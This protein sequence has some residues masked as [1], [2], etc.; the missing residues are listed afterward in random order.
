MRRTLARA[1]GVFVT[2]ALAALP[3]AATILIFAW[4]GGLLLRWLGPDSLIGGLLVAIGLG[5][6]GS[7]WLAYLIGVLAVSLGLFGLGLVV[8]SRLRHV[9]AAAVEALVQRIPF[10]RTV[11]ELIRRLV[12]L[13]AQR[14]AE[15][16]KSMS[17]VWC[18]FGGPGGAAVL[19][20]LSTPEP[21]LLG[22]KR[23]HAVLV[24]SAPVPVGGG[25]IYVPEQWVTSAEMGVEALTSVYMS[26]GVTS[27]QHVG[28]LPRD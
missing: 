13:I 26:M 11:Y 2:G 14:D 1:L 17:P 19:C 5:V 10:V 28:T 23:Y 18:H 25:L 27:S 4:A 3:L 22:G 12:E 9:P 20:L 8:Q 6:T 7:Q 21:V 15:G 24:P 16:L